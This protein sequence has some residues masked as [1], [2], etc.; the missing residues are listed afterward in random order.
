VYEDGSGENGPF[1][2][3]TNPSGWLVYD[4]P[5]EELLN[6]VIIHHSALPLSDGPREIQKLHME[7]KGFADVG[8]HF[9]IDQM[10][11]L[12][13][14]RALNV[15][16]AHT[17]G[18][19]YASVGICLIGN[20]EEIT[21]PEDQ[22]GTLQALLTQLTGQFPKITSLAGHRDLNT[23]TLCPGANLYPLLPDL[24]N[25]HKLEYL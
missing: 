20:F 1:N 17:F 14:G 15:R 5:L 19:N 10:G 4:Q 3:L 11:E 7:E 13:E 23:G 6:L 9:L 8:Y 21:P 12:F 25:Q 24:A 18:S 22:L 16:G 2:A